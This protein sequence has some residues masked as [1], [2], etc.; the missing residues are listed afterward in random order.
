FP[1]A[2]ESACTD[3]YGSPFLIFSTR[4]A[5][6]NLSNHKPKWPPD[7]F[8]G[9]LWS[10][11]YRGMHRCSPIL[12]LL[13]AGESRLENLLM[14]LAPGKGFHLGRYVSRLAPLHHGLQHV[15]RA[16]IDTPV[17]AAVPPVLIVVKPAVGSLVATF[18]FILRSCR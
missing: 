4:H 15:A 13:P 6:K 16:G 7:F 3:Q 1:F 18:L 8:E 5:S 12:P 9:S 14:R 17:L 10:N 2:P 11:R